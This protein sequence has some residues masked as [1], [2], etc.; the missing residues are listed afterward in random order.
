MFLAMRYLIWIVVV[1]SFSCTYADEVFDEAVEAVAL[2]NIRQLTFSSMGFEKAG[3]AYFSPDGQTIIFQAVPIGKEHY[4]IYAMNLNDGAPIMV[5]RAK[6][7]CTCAYFRPDGKKIIFASSHDDPNL[8]IPD[9]E[10]EVPGYKRQGGSYSWAFTP[11]MNIYEANPDG[12][13]LVPLTTG[14]FYHAE[15][16]YSHDGLRIVF[17]S[18]ESGS[19]NIYTMRTDGSN[20]VCVT[21]TTSCYNGGPFFS[22]DDA[23]I[24]FR[25]DR[26]TPND[27]Q[28]YTINADGTDERQLTYNNAVN[29][30]PYWH[31]SGKVV[32]FTTSLHGHAHYEIYL[33]NVETLALYRLTHNK[34]FDGLPVFSS[35]GKKVMW[36]SKRGIDSSQLFIADFCMPEQL[37]KD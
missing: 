31:P 8:D 5:S 32:A 34:A 17:A 16:A 26:H 30:A 28:I 20:I 35:C 7:A 18:N 13:D 37:L 2:K 10:Q 14:P 4:Q 3:E 29:W 9:Y 11:Y 6:G 15:C 24:V 12:S 22:P 33:L 19:M 21:N 1:L 36:T 23:S 27:L 25:A